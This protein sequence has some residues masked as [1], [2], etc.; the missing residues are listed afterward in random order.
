MPKIELPSET[1]RWREFSVVFFAVA[2][3]LVWINAAISGKMN[4][5]ALIERAVE[6]QKRSKGVAVIPIPLEDKFKFSQHN[7]LSTMI[8]LAVLGSSTVMSVFYDEFD[9]RMYNFSVSSNGLHASIGQAQY[10][11]DNYSNIKFMFISFDWALGY[12]F[13]PTE[14]TSAASFRRSDE[15]WFN[16][17]RSGLR[18]SLS[19]TQ[20]LFTVSQLQTSLANDAG[21]SFLGELLGLTVVETR[22]PTGE[23]VAYFG[24]WFPG[25]GGFYP[26][27]SSRLQT[28]MQ[29][30]D[31]RRASDI[32][33]EA[34][35]A[36]SPYRAV[37]RLTSGEPSRIY[38]DHLA[39]FSASLK[40]RGGRLVL[41]LPPLIP[42]L[43]SG[44]AAAGPDARALRKMK[45]ALSSWAEA[46]DVA[47]IDGGRS[48]DVGC[49][50]SEFVDAHHTLSSC[51]K[52]PF[53]G[54]QSRIGRPLI[55]QTTNTTGAG[56][57]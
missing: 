12:P 21:L 20:A 28:F 49:D 39:R 54:A 36:S 46:N 53:V 48:E 43:E 16:A 23:R 35:G 50:A 51:F 41:L 56:D 8:Q 34:L 37:L 22:C 38:L 45:S 31:P 6:W 27:G 18:R 57:R 52:K 29:P 7:D 24:T 19:T 14:P 5:P 33:Q 13:T 10:L 2:A 47:I 32:L 30:L 17:H 26:D 25:C 15:N 44:I 1:R 55:L 11:L 42:G 4:E 3:L 9:S 40:A